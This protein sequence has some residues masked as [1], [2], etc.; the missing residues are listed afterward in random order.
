MSLK[1]RQ[2]SPSVRRPHSSNISSEA[3]GPIKAKFH[4]E[5]S[6]VGGIKVCSVHLGEI[7]KMAATPIYGKNPL[8]IFFS[9]T[10]GP[11]AL[12]LGISMTDMDP[13]KFE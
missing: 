9:G 10:K 3:T 4:M 13:I 5:P 1:Y 2:A 7:G 6:W 11:I 12:G 8:K